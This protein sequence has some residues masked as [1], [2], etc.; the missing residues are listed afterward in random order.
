VKNQSGFT[1]TELLIAI[2]VSAIASVLMVTAFVYTYGSVVVE[3]SKAAMVRDS[4]LF[5]RR[6]IDD[7]RISNQVLLSNSITD[8]FGPVGGWVTSDPANVLVVTSPASDYNKN[9]IYDNDTGYPFQHEVIY[10]SSNT[11]MYR[12]L[13]ANPGAIG[14][15]QTTTCP[16]ATVDCANDIKLIDNLDNLLFQFYDIDNALTTDPT[17]AR[18]VQ[19]TVNL[20]KKVNGQNITTSNVTRVTLRNEN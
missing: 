19:I 9:F 16:I 15:L 18:S 12:R 7:I 10:F 20:S 6:M 3:Q 14:A 17:I 13:L 8:T 2:A 4:Q 11:S 1:I 5:L